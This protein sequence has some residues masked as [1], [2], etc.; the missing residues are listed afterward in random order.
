MRRFILHTDEAE[1]GRQLPGMDSMLTTLKVLPPVSIE[2]ISSFARARLLYPEMRY[3]QSSAL[4]IGQ[5]ALMMLVKVSSVRI[6]EILRVS[7][8]ILSRLAIECLYS[9]SLDADRA[10][11]LDIS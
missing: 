7:L 3:S 2:M 8:I 5:G 1:R 10:M 9:G 6:N 11:M 4:E